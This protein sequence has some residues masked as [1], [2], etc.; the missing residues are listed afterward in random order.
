ML[1]DISFC[2]Y[3]IM[4]GCFDVY[5][6]TSTLTERFENLKKSIKMIDADFVGLVDTFRWTDTF[7]KD[8][9]EEHFGYKNNYII[10]M[11]D[12]RVGKK[13]GVTVMTNLDIV[14]FDTVTAFNRDYIRTTIN[15]NSEKL[16]IYTTYLDDLSED[17]R[18]EQISSLLEQVTHP[19]I[20][21]GDLNTFVKSDVPK[22][23]SSEK[24]FIEK[25][26]EVAQKIIPIV[27]DMKRGEVIGKIEDAGLIDAFGVYDPTMPSHLFPAD[28]EKPFIRVD[29]FFHSKKLKMESPKVHKEGIFDKTSDHYP[30]SVILSDQP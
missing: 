2:S 9:L 3:N 21:H 5:E 26:K 16:S 1:V 15:L 14:A 30:I 7:T 18:L 27:N 12:E 10:D 24:V 6:D 23:L 25:N 29:Y 11:N 20:I 8:S 19:T 4:S 22:M 17:T 28:I 13:V